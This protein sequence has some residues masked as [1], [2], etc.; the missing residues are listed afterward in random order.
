MYS[1][2]F[3][4]SS[5]MIYIAF[6]TH[7][8]ACENLTFR[9]V[10]LRTN[11]KFVSNNSIF[12]LLFFFKFRCPRKRN[13]KVSSVHPL[14]PTSGKQKI[15]FSITMYF[16]IKKEW[17]SIKQYVSKLILLQRTL[18]RS[19]YP[20]WKTGKLCKIIYVTEYFLNDFGWFEARILSAAAMFFKFLQRFS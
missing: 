5:Q 4:I 17:S 20:G 7:H 13:W 16:N 8:N 1:Q 12:L 11:L 9:S 3:M 14:L 18:E 6:W 2:L 10:E 15:F 19:P